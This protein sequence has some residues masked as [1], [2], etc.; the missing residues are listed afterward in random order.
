MIELASD[1][2][3]NL[4]VATGREWLETNG[5]G[6]YAS[7]TIIG[8]NTRRYHGLLVA[9]TNPP[10]ERMVLLS[11]LEETLVIGD[12]RFGLG[13]NRYPGAIHPQ[14]YQF[15]Q[16]FR[17]DPFPR[18][19]YRAGG[20][21]L[22]K[23]VCMIH[24]ENTVI[25]RYLVTPTDGRKDVPI[26]L[27]L[28][29]LIAFRDHHALTHENP[30]LDSSFS[31]DAGSIR[32]QPYSSL[33][34]M[35]LSHSADAVEPTG[36]WYRGFEY[37][38][39]QERGLDFREDLFNPCALRHS[40]A[41]GSSM[42]VIASTVPHEVSEA[43]GLI[44]C[45]IDRRTALVP[46]TYKGNPL[47]DPLYRAAD[48]FIV[49]R[50]DQKTIIAGYHWFTDWGRDTM[51]ALP[52][53]TVATGRYEIARSILQEFAKYVDYG[54][55]PNRFPD[56]GE[57]PEYNTVDATLWYFE[58][59]RAYV[60]QTNDLDFVRKNLYDV[61]IGIV[62]WHVRGTRYGIRV[63][64]DGLLTSGTEGEQLTWMDARVGDWVVTPRRGKPVEIQALWYNAVCVLEELS[65]RFEAY[66][67]AGKYAK[68]AS[69]AKRSFRTHFWNAETD[70]LFDVIDGD[71]RDGSIRPNQLIAVSLRYS[72]VTRERA[73]KILRVVE[74]D[75]VTPY[76]LRSLAPS[77]PK[78]V[79]QYGGDPK[80]RD[81]AYHQGTVWSWLMGPYISALLR[82]HKG[83][84]TVKAKANGLL[85]PFTE[86]LYHAGLGQVSEIFDGDP[87]H[88]PR[89]CIGQAWSVGEL[90]RVA[91]SLDPRPR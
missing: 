38:M 3:G 84:S 36:Y 89:G 86:H 62:D 53:L 12:Q 57:A 59:V 10:T 48:R 2:C 63:D 27:E 76:G 32:L 88:T 64:D 14:G 81:G 29:P 50:G 19:T 60:E 90:L 85:E 75:L 91:V 70:C 41:P 25:V 16:R 34:P 21:E 23:A 6:G 79:G 43:E 26:S 77:D 28:R 46:A 30:A 69:K 17:L 1:I 11:K 7:S 52:G 87:P 18:W 39:E 45:E 71:T 54:M 44:R 51:I 4:E 73:L 42:F 15:L 67:T 5:L 58:A 47:L 82:V 13:V 68:M 55:I 8:L 37:W 33:N 83:S 20:V 74:R 72:M 40:F 56:A 49:A 9:A 35:Y 80:R 65:Y 31:D 22:E 66:G 78:Y 61:L 24:G